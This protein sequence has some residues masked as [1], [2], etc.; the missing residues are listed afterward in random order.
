MQV[1]EAENISKKYIIDHQKKRL[2]GY[3][4]R[5]TTTEKIK[6][7]FG[8]GNDEEFEKEDFWALKGVSFSVNQGDRVG[9]VGNNGA[10]K[11][12]LLK[13]LSK[14]TEPSS[15]HIKIQGRVASLLEVGT[16]F[17]PELTGR[18]NIFL[19][20][21][22]LGMK[23]QEIKN[24]FDEIIDFAGVEK[25]LDTPVKRYSSGMYVRLGFAIAA[26]LNP[27]ILIV[28]E[29]LAVGDAEFQKKCLGK[30]RDVS[31][32]G[33]TLLFVSHNLTA[34]QSLC[35]KTFYFEQGKLKLQGETNHV[36]ANYLSHVATKQLVREWENVEDAPGNDEVRLRRIG[37]EPEYQN[38][39]R[40]IDVRTPLKIEVSF[41]NCVS[42]AELN[43]SLHLFTVTG[44]CIF[45]IATIP[46]SFSTGLIDASV[47]IPG[48][49]L[50]DE[51]YV[52]SIMIVKD[53]ST[54]LYQM[55]D[56]LSFEIED[57]REISSSWHGK[58]PGFVRPQFN[59]QIS[60]A[61]VLAI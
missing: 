10:G 12:T 45:N 43:L 59:F 52:V 34:V 57:Y 16:G 31:E 40:H 37:L 2:K 39:L 25:F 18:E 15:G 8:Q 26:H 17:H 14:I 9:I 54:I 7:F 47:M 49:F 35:N 3:S 41:W 13:I 4:F 38:N 51:S 32:S 29:V 5:E 61:E 44:D 58:W 30:M 22:I 55:A 24:A 1:I 36:I 23:T 48:N 53:T 56:A 50:N 11:S 20:G 6:S 27:E 42:D 60:Q 21:A 46:Q 19:N 33:R 28:D